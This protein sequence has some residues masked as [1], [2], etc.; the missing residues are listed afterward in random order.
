MLG[1]SASFRAKQ[2]V[3]EANKSTM[4]YEVKRVRAVWDP[5]LSIPGTDRRGG[6][7][8]PEGTRYGGQITDRFGRQCGWGLVRRIANMVS[9][10]GESLEDR[11]DRRRAR[12]GGKRRVVSPATPELDTP[13]LDLNENDSALAESLGEVIPTPEP[14]KPRTVKPR[15]VTNVDTPEAVEPKPEPR[16]RRA[17][18]RRPQGNLRP[19]EQRRMER[20]LEQP[21]AP[22]TGLE[23]PSVE[24]V[25]TPEQ[26][27]DAVPTEE[28]RPYVLRKYNEYARNV[29]KIREEGGDAGMLT[30]REW[31][32]INKDNLRSAWKDIH[33]KDAPESFEPP[34]PQP[35]RPRRRR[36]RAVEEAASTRSPSLRNDKE[37]VA[38]EP[39]PE[40]KKPSRPKKPSSIR[41]TGAQD[42]PRRPAPPT[43]SDW[44]SAG[45]GRWNVGNWLITASEDENGNFLR[46]VASTPDRRYAE[47]VDVDEV[48]MAMASEDDLFN[49]PREVLWQRDLEREGIF[50]IDN[51]LNDEV[52]GQRTV[53]LND[54]DN[55]PLLM[56]DV[57]EEDM[58]DFDQAVEN[59][60]RQA[61]QT[62][63]AIQK[64]LD[65]GKIRKQD[66]WID[67]N[68]N[69][70]NVEDIM[71]TLNGVEDAWRFVQT[72]NKPQPLPDPL[73]D[74]SW[75]RTGPNH[76]VKNGLHLF[77][78]F[79]QSGEVISGRIENR[80]FGNI[81][82][83]EFAA[84]P[85]QVQNFVDGLYALAG[86][87]EMIA[88]KL[89]KKGKLIGQVE[90]E[91]F[92]REDRQFFRHGLHLSDDQGL[93][94]GLSGGEEF[95]RNELQR[96]IQSLAYRGLI[97]QEMINSTA[98]TAYAIKAKLDQLQEVQERLGL[99]DSDYFD[100]G[101]G[102]TISIG[103]VKANLK[104]IDGVLKEQFEFIKENYFYDERLASI[105]NFEYFIDHSEPSGQSSRRRDL[106]KYLLL[107]GFEDFNGL[108]D[109]HGESSYYDSLSLMIENLKNLP[110]L[111]QH[112]RQV[113]LIHNQLYEL[114][115]RD[116]KFAEKEMD[117]AEMSE[118]LGID[119][120]FD[121]DLNDTIEGLDELVNG[122]RAKIELIKEDIANLASKISLIE[123]STNERVDLIA[124]L[125]KLDAEKHYFN[126]VLKN[127][128]EKRKPLDD[129]RIANQRSFDRDAAIANF[130]NDSMLDDVDGTDIR[131][132][133]NIAERAHHFLRGARGDERNDDF[134][135]PAAIMG[136][137]MADLDDLLR[138][139]PEDEQMKK[140]QELLVD[141]ESSIDQVIKQ[142]N[143]SIAKFKISPTRK[144]LAVLRS[145]A[146]EAVKVKS[147]VQTQRAAVEELNKPHRLNLRSLQYLQV[148]I[149]D[150]STAYDAI[151]SRIRE[152]FEKDLSRYSEGGLVLGSEIENAIAETR[153]IFRAEFNSVRPSPR[154]IE[155]INDMWNEASRNAAEAREVFNLITE[156]LMNFSP[157]GDVDSDKSRAQEIAGRLSV[158]AKDVAVNAVQLEELG[159]ERSS[160]QS[161]MNN[162]LIPQNPVQI[163]FGG[164]YEDH[165]D[166]INTDNIEERINSVAG[167]ISDRRIAK[168]ISD[169]DDAY[170]KIDKFDDD[171]I[172]RFP[173]GDITAGDAKKALTESSRVYQEIRN[174]RANDPNKAIFTP[175][176]SGRGDLTDEQLKIEPL[177]QLATSGSEVDIAKVKEIIELVTRNRDTKRGLL[178]ELQEASLAG[179][180]EK[181]MNMRRF[182]N[183]LSQFMQN[184]DID[185]DGVNLDD[186][187]RDELLAQV[188]EFIKEMT[189]IK[190]DEIEDQMG[191]IETKRR[192]MGSN[193]AQMDDL[194]K[195]L[196]DGEISQA[197]FNSS[198]AQLV[199]EYTKDLLSIVGDEDKIQIY[200]W[201]KSEIPKM[202]ERRIRGLGIN[203]E[204]I[205]DPLSDDEVEKVDKKITSQ[206]RKGIARRLDVL[207]N[208]INDRYP[209][210]IQRPW[211]TMDAG[212]FD[213][214]NPEQQLEYI[215]TAYSHERIVGTNGILYNA[216]ADVNFR[217]GYI[218]V[219]VTF[220][221][222]DENGNAIREAGS[223]E[224]YINVDEGYVDNKYMVLGR[225]SPI[226]K[227][228]G[229]QT[230]YNQ[231]AF[232]Y[233]SQIGV[234]EARVGT[235]D[236][237][238]YV[239]A[240]IGFIQQD[241]LSAG[242]MRD[243]N[244]IL[245]RY[246]QIGPV[247]IIGSDAEYRR[248]LALYDMWQNGADISHQDFIFAFDST[249][250]F[251]ALR[252]KEWF[253][254]NFGLGYGIFNFA[255]QF[256]TANPGEAAQRINT[257]LQASNA[258]G[259]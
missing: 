201:A 207:Q 87:R 150:R 19:S 161:E 20:E 44:V 203:D 163:L 33:G 132:L 37:P 67:R 181:V 182:V 105:F 85:S 170:A 217:D 15:R 169:I 66:E 218:V 139:L 61:Q 216:V 106:L 18:R 179:D 208:Y 121:E 238:P 187:E 156:E 151:G 171:E 90:L 17:P 148:Y 118:A 117:L 59:N 226:D 110:N 224:R 3:T 103:E 212:L 47:G 28:F 6:W 175:R 222:I 141:S 83:Q 146:V 74:E 82:Q 173:N 194:K 255:E 98:K 137:T 94:I 206:I 12:R 64:L 125:L 41:P 93:G 239:W 158:A 204:S 1:G 192:R 21:G 229:I 149:N 43:P 154:E 168:Y 172:L 152:I 80:T 155:R 245:E 157:T 256:V 250:K 190:A 197:V 231:H 147:N 191:L 76:W 52:F 247:G 188:D 166:G 92:D 120:Q 57:S 162:R 65:D 178:I 107:N 223:S 97:D 7:R 200:N 130:Y 142:L 205:L 233:L 248:V 9:N 56:N 189:G 79:N 153:R 258:G 123:T 135:A 237:G 45:N 196:A 10:V 63:E 54:P 246:R 24:Q 62:R 140:L 249:D 195:Q 228:A 221:E 68:G 73:L 81:F 29:R 34:T 219:D 89:R 159:R 131:K 91:G 230:I 144:N 111:D 86:G 259:N 116:I 60:I 220:N 143:D 145:W 75:V 13:N 51:Y 126:G 11:G 70:V 227:N 167:E 133:L 129:I 77:L 53:I 180:L 252:Q 114:L 254:V 30:R 23:E 210:V 115:M 236:D 49:A 72:S 27:S 40:P 243:I 234:T 46:F 257:R 186:R 176:E 112:Q 136:R 185:A 244:D 25:L 122:A 48:V 160:K 55:F 232:M 50:Q 14:P 58:R 102:S 235:M 184:L 69:G 113:D 177:I 183:S 209:G 199:S 100:T 32:A 4:V 71:T 22:R 214:L 96:L 119:R 202:V 124:N 253:R 174:A 138:G 95:Y 26:A 215:K 134:D 36:Q 5:S 240:R 31:Y 198:V 88:P 213:S 2:F 108:V 78:E 42:K 251:R 164:K 127:L 101:N 128:I 193:V 104:A 84:D 109:L 165:A 241:R 99:S 242:Q 211:E 35:R 8:C 39:K 225:R 38:V 16:P